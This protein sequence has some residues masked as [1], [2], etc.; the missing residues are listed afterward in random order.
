[1]SVMVVEGVEGRTEDTRWITESPAGM[2]AIF[3]RAPFMVVMFCTYKLR[4]ARKPHPIMGYG[5]VDVDPQCSSPS[6]RHNHVIRQL[7]AQG[8]ASNHMV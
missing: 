7:A 2:S 8:L 3:T 4:Y 6:G 5:A 1:M